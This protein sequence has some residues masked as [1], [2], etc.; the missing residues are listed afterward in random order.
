MPKVNFKDETSL[1]V[2]V[3]TGNMKKDMILKYAVILITIKILKRSV[4]IN[5]IE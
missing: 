2:E 5:F 3:D 1:I 4:N